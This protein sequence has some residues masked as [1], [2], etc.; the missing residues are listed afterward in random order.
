MADELGHLEMAT[1]ANQPLRDAA[2]HGARWALFYRLGAL[3]ICWKPGLGATP[4]N[5]TRLE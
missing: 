4:N 2:E 5:R 3:G 1:Q